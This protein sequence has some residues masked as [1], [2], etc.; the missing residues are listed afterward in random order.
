MLRRLTPSRISTTR[1]LFCGASRRYASAKFVPLRSKKNVVRE[2]TLIMKAIGN[3]LLLYFFIGFGWVAILFDK[4]CGWAWYD[5]VLRILEV[6]YKSCIFAMY[7]TLISELTKSGTA[8]EQI[9][10]RCR[11][12]E[13][14][15]EKVREYLLK[16]TGVYVK[17]GQLVAC[18]PQVFPLEWCINMKPCLDNGIGMN[19]GEL[20]RAIQTS[21]PYGLDANINDLF[22]DFNFEPVKAASLAEV[23]QAKR[24]GTGEALAVKVQYLN[25]QTQLH[26][27]VVVLKRLLGLIGW[28]VSHDLTWVGEVLT[29]TLEE[30]LDFL[31][32]A[33]NCD[34]FR[35][36]FADWEQVS[37]PIVY[38]DLSSERVLTM[39]YIKG[40]N[41]NNAKEIARRK[42]NPAAVANLAAEVMASSIFEHGFLHADPHPANIFI[43]PLSADGEWRLQ[44]LDHGLYQD[45]TPEFQKNY[46]RLWYGIGINN[47]TEIESACVDL[48]VGNAPLL[49][50]LLS[51]SPKLVDGVASSEVPLS[52]K[53]FFVPHVV[54][55]DVSLGFLEIMED[56]PSEMVLVLKCNALLQSLQKE[57]KV[58]ITFNQVMSSAALRHLNHLDMQQNP[59]RK[60]RN[61]CE[62]RMKA[63]QKHFE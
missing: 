8:I 35:E 20:F 41:I 32:E 15:S 60:T 58:P 56:I 23:H 42:I 61:M 16:F 44:W 9:L 33:D 11:C 39:E 12:H 29:K 45:L 30:E 48:G 36:M 24:K 53:E 13:V 26:A 63:L 40:F 3:P 57:L 18:M 6:S 34:K 27:D 19:R 51:G 21:R 46:A 25:L 37:S 2:P 55:S 17:M 10:A 47:K 31:R 38:R 28:E 7:Y 54:D 1:A 5:A 22:D 43:E 50:E 62:G 49:S 59:S 14:A 52:K 4:F